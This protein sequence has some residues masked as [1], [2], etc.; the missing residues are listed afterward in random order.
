MPKYQ[1]S[2]CRTSKSFIKQ[3]SLTLQRYVRHF[4]CTTSSSGSD[5]KEKINEFGIEKSEH[6][7]FKIEPSAGTRHRQTEKDP[8]SF[9]EYYILCHNSGKLYNNKTSAGPSR[10]V[11][12]VEKDSNTMKFLDSFSSC[13]ELQS[14]VSTDLKNLNRFTLKNSMMQGIEDTLAEEFEMGFLDTD[15]HVEETC[16]LHRYRNKQ[17]GLPQTSRTTHSQVV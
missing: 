4:N 12:I 5:G 9:H 3:C 10:Q 14:F 1:G 17:H 8:S 13:A 15:R 16:F 2:H 11:S 7:N 6:S